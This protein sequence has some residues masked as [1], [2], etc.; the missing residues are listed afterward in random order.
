MTAALGG[1]TYEFTHRYYS[2]TNL[3]C[4]AARAGW[5]ERVAAARNERSDA[6][7]PLA[8]LRFRCCRAGYEG[9][10]RK[11]GFRGVFLLLGQQERARAQL[12]NTACATTPLSRR[13]PTT[14]LNRAKLN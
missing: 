1:E 13:P 5:L 10:P 2:D 3:C 8:Q 6:A 14:L 12:R 11:T 7:D 9:E 4:G